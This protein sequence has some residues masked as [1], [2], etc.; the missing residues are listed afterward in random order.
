MADVNS[1]FKSQRQILNMKKLKYEELLA[2]QSIDK[3]AKCHL[4]ETWLAEKDTTRPW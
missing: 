3:I 4:N 2:N 1:K